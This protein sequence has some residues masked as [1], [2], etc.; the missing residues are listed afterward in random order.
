MNLYQNASGDTYGKQRLLEREQFPLL[1]VAAAMTVINVHGRLCADALSR[2]PACMP[3]QS[4]DGVC[5][6]P[7]N[8]R[9]AGPFAPLHHHPDGLRLHFNSP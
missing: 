8:R 3:I 9:S 4:G 1:V 2:R 6:L 5:R 7:V